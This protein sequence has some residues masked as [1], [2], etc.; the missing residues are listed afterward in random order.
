MNRPDTVSFQSLHMVRDELL[1][2][3]EQA[4]RDLE[5]YVSSYQE[6]NNLQA[7][8][9]GI[10]QILGILKVLE[11][12]GASMLT[13]ELLETANLIEPGNSEPVV[14]KNIELVS[15]TFFVLTRYLEYVQQNER[16][17]PVLLIPYINDLRK[18]RRE[19]LLPESFFFHANIGN[20]PVPSAVEPIV[21]TDAE[22]KALL[23]RLRHMYQLGLLGILRN[24]Q[25]PA[26][27]ALMRRALIRMQRL[28][29]DKPLAVLWWLSNL[30]IETMINQK[31][32]VIEPR[33]MLLSRIDRII[34]Q[35][36]KGGRA[37]Y[38]AAA[39]KGLIKEILYLLSLS[40]SQ[41][42]Q[43][44]NILLH[45]GVRRQALNDQQLSAERQSL[46]GPSSATIHALVRVLNGE[47][48]NVKKVLETS[49]QGIRTIDDVDGLRESL[50]NIADSLNVVGMLG[51]S[52]SLKDELNRL[53]DWQNDAEIAELELEHLAK[54][55]LYVESAVH[56]LEYA[57]LSGAD[58]A[59][60]SE[61][62][63]NRVISDNE[64][65]QAEKIVLQE[66]EAGLS[67]CKRAVT[68]FTESNFDP[69]HISN[70][71]RTLN[72]VRGGLY[73][74]KRA[75]AA[76]V[77]GSCVAFVDDVLMGGKQPAAIKELLETFADA[78]I[79]VEYFL[80][81]AT[82][83]AKLDDSALQV[84]EESVAALGYPV[85][86]AART[87]AAVASGH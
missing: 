61:D 16:V 7:C 4:A 77:L 56:S 17:L 74:L 87:K 10:R 8:I 76:T 32:E 75:R 15:N 31:M 40:G 6:I 84:A 63:Q 48:N 30:V 53:R 57:K 81:T 65:S 80:D 11:L 42:P 25:I 37:A 20:P 71:S 83:A 54:T 50:A 27:L 68:A 72:S 18:Y 49:A 26:S 79:S 23:V 58:L 14:E 9:N 73:M 41:N 3:I 70:I 59:N 44:Q 2:T 28:G 55:L 45:Y 62:G 22:F 46:K 13:E 52:A 39:P 35:V 34:R 36:Q 82:V 67:L 5:V 21:V 51:P 64:L 69:G 24:K 38:Q 43:V 1:S 33:K 85:N 66:C 47:V 29:N 86:R 60:S 12:K 19:P 78:I